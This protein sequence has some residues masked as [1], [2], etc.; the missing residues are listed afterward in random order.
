MNS[1]RST[2]EHKI[3]RSLFSNIYSKSYSSF[4]SFA[5]LNSIFYFII[6]GRVPV[7]RYMTTYATDSK[8]SLIDVTIILC[9]F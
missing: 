8:S 1:L 2:L 9:I 3:E 5:A 7:N 4:F 6:Q